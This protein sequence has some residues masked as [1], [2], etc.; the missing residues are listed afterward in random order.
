ME[1]KKIINLLEH[2]DHNDISGFQTKNGILLMTKTMGTMV[3]ETEMIL[4]LSLAQ[5]L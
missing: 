4:L 5:K 3:K 2:S 1:S